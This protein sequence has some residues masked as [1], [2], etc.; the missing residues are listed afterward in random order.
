[1]PLPTALLAAILL[2]QPAPVE[3]K[4]GRYQ[5][6]EG[7]FLRIVGTLRGSP[8]PGGHT[9]KGRRWAGPDGK[10]LPGT[11]EVPADVDG[12]DRVPVAVW[13]RSTTIGNGASMKVA[14]H[15][16]LLPAGS[17]PPEGP[18][19]FFSAM[20][21]PEMETR[22]VAS[23]PKGTKKVDVWAFLAME[24]RPWTVAASAKLDLSAKDLRPY[25]RA[26]LF[27]PEAFQILLVEWPALGIEYFRSDGTLV[28]IPLARRTRSYDPLPK[29][30]RPAGLE[31]PL[32]DPGKLAG[33]W[34]AR[35]KDGTEVPLEAYMEA[36]VRDAA[37]SL[38]RRGLPLTFASMKSGSG[39]SIMGLGTGPAVARPEGL[40]EIRFQTQPWQRIVFRNL[41]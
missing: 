31:L 24:N 9:F 4:G 18:L 5:T 30:D 6:S 25:D 29:G 27:P 1:M 2:A 17:S 20:E 11:G 22:Q 28:R 19:E 10:Q 14:R 3:A 8:V 7:F 21:P 23:L 15:L 16:Y 13:T 34:V 26:G 32:L 33:R 40:A 12:V 38:L 37:G 35:L 41:P 36:E 39:P